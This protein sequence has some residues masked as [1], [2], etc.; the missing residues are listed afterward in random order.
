[1]K[2]FHLFLLIF[3]GLLLIFSNGYPQLKKRIA[4]FTF[5]DKTDNSW[6]WWDGRSPGDGM[7]DM[8]TTELVKSGNYMV[9]ERSEIARIIEEQELG[10]AGLVTA[11]S[12]AQMGQ[13]LGVELAVMG[14]VT[15]FG[16]SRGGTGTRIGGVSLGVSNQ[17]A[18]VAIDV[19]FVNTTTGEILA[20]D[21]VRKEESA[22]GFGISTPD[23][24]F[25]NRNDFDNSIVGKATREAVD[26]IIGLV[27]QQMKVLPW[28]G[29]IILVRDN[30]IYIKPGSDAGVQVGDEFVVF[31]QGEEL[32]DPDTGISLGSVETRVGSIEITGIVSGG[33][34]AIASIKT[35]SGFN[36]GDLVR[37]P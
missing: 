27:E 18:T 7:A 21:N 4:V 2:K 28:E 15:E 5:E 13:L 8:L 9:I 14:A 10:Q 11:Q 37:L 12:A 1:M 19:R 26:D 30:T 16:M 23:F 17:S 31:A 33:Q 22:S 29:K 25:N 35:G 3:F 20:A 36:V 34:A 24:R 32:I 6:R